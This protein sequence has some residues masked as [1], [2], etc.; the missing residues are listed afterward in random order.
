[1]SPGLPGTKIRLS[2]WEFVSQYFTTGWTEKEREHLGEELSDVLIY[3]IRLAEQ[4]HIDLPS[5]VIRKFDL[6]AVKY[7]S[8]EESV[9]KLRYSKQEKDE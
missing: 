2:N 6:N 3:L 9:A 7:P 1:M 8:G 5:A 4:C